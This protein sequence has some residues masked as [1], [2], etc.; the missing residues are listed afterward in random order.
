MNFL[1]IIPKLSKV[2]FDF[3]GNLLQTSLIVFK[4]TN[5]PTKAKKAIIAVFSV[6]VL[7]TIAYSGI[8]YL[9]E[10]IS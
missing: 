4:S 6:V 8:N 9:S 7:T 5:R 3:F 1:N 10:Q 2:T